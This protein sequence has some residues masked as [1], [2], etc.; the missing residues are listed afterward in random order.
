MAKKVI[1]T[2]NFEDFKGL[3]LRSSPLTIDPNSALELTNYRS[4]EGGSIQ[5]AEGYSVRA[6]YGQIGRAHV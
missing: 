5:G 4:S 2:K 1:W 3:D 6:N